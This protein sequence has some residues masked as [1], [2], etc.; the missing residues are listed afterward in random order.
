MPDLLGNT[1]ALFFLIHLSQ[2]ISAKFTRNH[3]VIIRLVVLESGLGLE[4]ELKSVFAGL[5]LENLDLDLGSK[6]SDLD[7]KAMDLDLDLDLEALLAS[8]F[9]SP[10]YLQDRCKSL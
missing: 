4:F 8:P 10:L 5:G 9:S 2:G 6:D 3:I 7:L 1:F